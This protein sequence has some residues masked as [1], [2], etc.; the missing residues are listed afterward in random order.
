MTTRPGK[1]IVHLPGGTTRELI[2][3]L[4][5]HPVVYDKGLFRPPFSSLWL[6]SGTGERLPQG[7]TLAVELSSPADRIEAM[8]PED[9]VADLQSALLVDSPAGLYVPDFLERATVV[10][11]TGGYLV[12]ASFSSRG[13]L[14]EPG[15]LVQAGLMG[16][17]N[18]YDDDGDH[19]VSGKGLDLTLVGDPFVVGGLDLNPA[20]PTHFWGMS[21]S[22]PPREMSVS[23]VLKVTALGDDDSA[24][25][26]INDADRSGASW[27]IVSHGGPTS[28]QFGVLGVVQGIPTAVDVMTPSVDVGDW[29]HLHIN[30]RQG[31]LEAYVQG[32]L[33]D[34]DLAIHD[35]E[36]IFPGPSLVIPG[37]DTGQEGVL[38]FAA[39]WDRLLTATEVGVNHDYLV[40][41]LAP[42]GIALG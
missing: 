17:W 11:V 10:P 38:A 8:D 12:E 39:V 34:T 42:Q 32:V 22:V 20:L 13:P 19:E 1:L 21:I 18:L 3:S 9:L 27:Q 7:F 30:R 31:A 6:W 40:G 23:L 25:L 28:F 15:S 41:L 35:E 2:G 29:V 16:R 24:L 26:R 4:R 5:P 36:L 14:V 37:P 33:A